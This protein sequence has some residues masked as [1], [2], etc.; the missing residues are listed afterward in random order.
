[1]DQLDFITMSGDLDRFDI[2][3]LNSQNIHDFYPDSTYWIYN[4]GLTED[5]VKCL[6]KF[7]NTEVVD[8]SHKADHDK[9]THFI[10]QNLAKIQQ[11]F[12]DNK[13]TNHLIELFDITLKS[14]IKRWDFFCS[15]KPRVI[16]DFYQN[17]NG[18]FVWLDD[19]A[20]IIN[21]IDT[22]IFDNF[23]V[24]VTIRSKYNE[25]C[26]GISPV[27]AGVIFFSG[28][29]DSLET[30]VNSW[31]QRMIEINPIEDPLREQTSLSELCIPTYVDSNEIKYNQT[32]ILRLS[33]TNITVSYLPARLY[34]HSF[35][36]HGINPKLHKILH[37]K[38]GAYKS[39]FN[40][41]LIN[42]ALHDNL[43][44]YHR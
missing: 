17:F 16:K 9:N 11:Y 18:N 42:E 31:I 3:K 13:Y 19:D 8:W 23:D 44:Y 24:G 1:M 36:G 7:D 5:E 6:S 30:F 4:T 10:E 40:K 20:I 26:W 12:L 2:L 41:R 32:V 43:R 39:K 21:K 29:G 22:G 28:R 25:K 33:N 27:N 34:N 15:Q 37:F 14:A 35:F 38:G